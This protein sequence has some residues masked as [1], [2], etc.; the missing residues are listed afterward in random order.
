MAALFSLSTAGETLP[1]ECQVPRSA[2]CSI[3]IVV[4]GAD[5]PSPRPAQAV[6]IALANFFT[7]KGAEY[8]G[9]LPMTAVYLGNNTI[10]IVLSFM[11][12]PPMGPYPDLVFEEKIAMGSNCDDPKRFTTSSTS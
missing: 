2:D 6:R 10:R 9:L 11:A 12:A 1:A 8:R 7:L 3:T 5:A 4:L